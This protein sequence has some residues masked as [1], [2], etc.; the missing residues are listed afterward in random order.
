VIAGFADGGGSADFAKV[1]SGT[2]TL[3][4]ANTYQGKTTIRDGVLALA[5]ASGI[6]QASST[7]VDESGRL[8]LATNLIGRGEFRIDQLTVADGGQL[9]VRA[10]QPLVSKNIVLYA[11]AAG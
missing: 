7:L 1:G 4:G 3:A 5:N 6:P 11:N 2:L 9:F 8:D 10:S